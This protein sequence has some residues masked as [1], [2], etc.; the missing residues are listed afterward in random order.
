HLGALRAGRF[1]PA[2][3]LALA[4]APGA[5]ARECRLA[6]P[7]RG[8]GTL[9]RVPARGAARLRPGRGEPLLFGEQLYWLPH[10]PGAALGSAD[11]AGLRTLRPGLHLGALRA[12]R[13][14]PAHALA[15]AAAPGAAARE[16]RLAAASAEAAAYLRGEALAQP[17][18][19]AGWTVVT[20]D[21]YPLGWGK[22]SGGQLKNHYPKG[23][24]RMG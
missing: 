20:V 5:A 10:A 15:L 2:H 4:A 17:G 21:G 22:V 6:A 16:C 9:G 23:L 11:L 12:G 24:R 1:E 8:C 14:E 3:A 19:A 13:F 7:A 18:L